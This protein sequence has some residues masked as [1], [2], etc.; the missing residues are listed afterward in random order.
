[1][2]KPKSSQPTLPTIPYNR[3]TLDYLSN[4]SLSHSVSQQMLPLATSSIYTLTEH[5]GT[6]DVLSTELGTL[7]NQIAELQKKDKASS[8]SNAELAK[9]L[10][11][12]QETLERIETEREKELNTRILLPPPETMQVQLVASTSLDRLE[13]Y[14]QDLNIGFL[15]AGC[16][17]GAI[18][19][20]LV[21]WAT[22]ESFMISR[23]SVVLFVLMVL[24]AIG[25]VTY[26]IHVRRRVSSIKMRML[27]SN[28]SGEQEPKTEET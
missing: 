12:V 5:T 1:M 15:L 18:L 22:D 26:I 20:V 4:P 28:P 14:S 10:Q 23:A 3:D 21:N 24:A 19:G 13:E 6:T 8:Q 9:S 11:G 7:R 2:E 27:Y 17:I 16:F 25:S